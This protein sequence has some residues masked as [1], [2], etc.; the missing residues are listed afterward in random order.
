[1][2]VTGNLFASHAGMQNGIEALSPLR[3]E[4]TY[5]TQS[6]APRAGLI[7][8]TE[9]L[10]RFRDATTFPRCHSAA[11]PVPR[12][13]G[14]MGR[15]RAPLDYRL[16]LLLMRLHVTGSSLDKELYMLYTKP[17]WDSAGATHIQTWCPFPRTESTE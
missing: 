4:L 13:P 3:L 1:V 7:R 2:A 11:K 5:S 14:R 6:P 10:G 8:L 17:R 16:A 9:N 15:L 12:G